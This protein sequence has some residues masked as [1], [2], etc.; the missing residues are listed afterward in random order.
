ML[1]YC[2]LKVRCIGSLSVPG[3]GVAGY[4]VA[5]MGGAYGFGV[6]KAK[7]FEGKC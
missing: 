2:A 4:C 1:F 3:V 7:G 5:G 6:N